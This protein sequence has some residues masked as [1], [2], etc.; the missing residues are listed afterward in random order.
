MLDH[1]VQAERRMGCFSASSRVCFPELQEKIEAAKAA[2]AGAERTRLMEE[3]ADIAHDE[4]FFIPFV[5][6][7]L[8]YGLAENLEWE[9][10]YAP[11]V[12]VNAMRFTQ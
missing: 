12:R 6:V 5:Q 11:R 8:V 9:P 2:P 4:F 7:Q 3:L 10:L 1:Q